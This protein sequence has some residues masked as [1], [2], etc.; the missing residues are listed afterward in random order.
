MPR[1]SRQ[2][3]SRQRSNLLW[4]SLAL[5]VVIAISAGT[6]W[7]WSH[8]KAPLDADSMCPSDGPLGHHVLLVDTT[9]PLNET[10]KAAVDLIVRRLVEKETPPGYLL[11]VFVLGDNFKLDAKPLVEL[12]N[13]GDAQGHSQLTE[14]LKQIQRRYRDR[15]IQPL[16]AQT[17]QM[18]RNEP[19]RES[20]ILEMLQMVHLNALAKRDVNGP[21]QV[22]VLSDLMQHSKQLSMYRDVPN[23]DAFAQSDYGHKTRISFKDTDVQIWLI[24]NANG[25]KQKVVVDFWQRY[26]KDNDATSVNLERLPG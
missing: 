25:A 9:D 14:N 3:R 23:Y 15:F 21:R 19:A 22:I 6:V 18:M 16:L 5:L 17:E 8:Q 13:P 2:A 4:A 1:K 26:F 20:P 7:W 10:Q 12:C 11:S 24:Q